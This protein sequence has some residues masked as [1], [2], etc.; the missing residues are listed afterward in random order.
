MSK[1]KHGMAAGECPCVPGGCQ[2]S[3]VRLLDEAETAE[4]RERMGFGAKREIYTD[5]Q[6]AERR[7]FL[8]RKGLEYGSGIEEGDTLDAMEQKV[9]AAINRKPEIH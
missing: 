6:A 3:N 5:E 4:V 1:C 8:T 9:M 7:T 2:G